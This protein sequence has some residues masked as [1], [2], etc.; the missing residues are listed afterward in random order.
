MIFFKKMFA[1]KILRFHEG[2]NRFLRM[3]MKIPVLGN[4]ISTQIFDKKNNGVRTAVGVVAQLGVTLYEFLRKYMY[5]LVFI[6]LPFL[7]IADICPLIG[8]HQELT[9]IFMFFFLSTL[10]GSL[11]NTTVLAMGD[12]EY[13]VVRVMLVTPYL[14]FLGNIIYKMISDF[15]YFTIILSLFVVSFFN[16]LVLSFVTMCARPIG[17]MLTILIYDNFKLLY[18]SRSAYNGSIMALSILLA[19]GIPLINRRISHEWITVVHPVFAFVML[20]FGAGA[21]YFLWWYKHYRKIMRVAM[22]I[23]SEV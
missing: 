10:C 16:S 22:H 5:V 12:R 9:I 20:L 23:K 6:Y 18:N 21:M 1:E 19:Y 17:E 13:L 7:I 14:S 11:A 15:I 4:L 8:L 3:L 2:T